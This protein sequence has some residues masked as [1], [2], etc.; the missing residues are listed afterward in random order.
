MKEYCHVLFTGNASCILQLKGRR[1]L[2]V[3]KSL[4][5]LSKYLGMYDEWRRIRLNHGLK[6]CSDT[7][8]FNSLITHSYPQMI[9]HAKNIIRTLED[10]R[11]AVEFIALSGLRPSESLSAISLFHREKENYLN[12][13]LL[14]LEHYKYPKVFFRRHKKTY[15]T[16]I[17]EQLLSSLEKAE[18]VTYNALWKYLKKRKKCSTLNIFRKIFCSFMRKR[19]VDDFLLNILQGRTPS[20]VFEKYYLR[21]DFKLEI[22]KV[23]SLLPE[24][25]KI[26]FN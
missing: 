17:D 20:T 7:F 10:R 18:A 15:V 21:P 12:A 3:M 1:R 26:L 23:R 19:G 22:E 11:H 9:E 2:N 6:W 25:R 14:I 4:S 13:E 24:L 5:M 16:I 8:N